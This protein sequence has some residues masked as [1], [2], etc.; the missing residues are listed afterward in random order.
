M[1]VGDTVDV[2]FPRGGQRELGEVADIQ[3]GSVAVRLRRPEGEA[4]IIV[5]TRRLLPNG[6][7]R[8]RLDL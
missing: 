5:S 1:T 6:P 2:Y 4:T 8:W 3:P 7:N